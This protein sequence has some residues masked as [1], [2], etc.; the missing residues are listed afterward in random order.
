MDAPVEQHTSRRLRLGIGAGIVLVVFGA[1]IAVLVA[2]LGPHGV[3]ETVTP[4]TGPNIS[5]AVPGDTGAATAPTSA[6]AGA[7]VYVH[8]LGEVNTPGL[9]QLRDGDRVVDAVAAAG[10]LTANAD[11]GQLNLARFLSDGEQIIVPAIGQEPAAA[12]GGTAPG[13]VGGAVNINTADAA[14][15]EQLAGVGPALAARIVAWRDANGRFSAVEDLLNVTGIGEKTLDG[16]R[17]SVV[18]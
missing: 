6:P 12:P 3:S 2:T 5:S 8:I 14:T 18:P 9:Y 10:G 13:A 4:P 17:D 15:L 1:G 16:F 7:E 11:Q